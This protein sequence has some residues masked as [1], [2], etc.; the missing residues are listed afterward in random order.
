MAQLH[1]L[2]WKPAWISHMGCHHACSE[3]LDLGLSRP[4]IYG[5]TGHAFALNVHEELCPSGPTAWNTD[6]VDHLAANIGYL[7]EG[8]DGQVTER[9]FEA[10]QRIAWALV[11]GC[12]D[13][14]VPCYAWELAIPEWYVIHGYDD[15]GYYYTGPMA[16]MGQMP[17]PSTQLARTEIG[18][19]SV[20]CVVHCHPSSDE[21]IVAAALDFAFDNA[22]GAHRMEN[23][24]SGPEGFE[25]W[26]DALESGAASRF[27]AGYNGEC[28]RECRVMAAEFLR[29]AKQRLGREAGL[30]DAAI[31]AYAAVGE[32][33]GRVV[34]RIPFKAAENPEAEAETVQDSEAAG[35]LREANAAEERGLEALQ[36]LRV[37]L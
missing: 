7:V 18:W 27:G 30:F 34:E 2:E 14:G 1:G 4:W 20:R 24:S 31:E 28:W 21:E 10:K 8:V 37:A 12:I 16:E 5:G 35:I 33:L 25:L 3:F 11:T 32:A 9:D 13:T 19:L 6:V 29:E 26:A 22:A 15:G 36:K 17:L 23:Y